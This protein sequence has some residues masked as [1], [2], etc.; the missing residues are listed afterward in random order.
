MLRVA[1]LTVLRWEKGVTLP[2][3]EQ[4]KV[5]CDLFDKSA[6]ELGLTGEHAEHLVT[7]L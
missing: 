6:S 5:L 1:N 7:R 3:P 2:H 4:L